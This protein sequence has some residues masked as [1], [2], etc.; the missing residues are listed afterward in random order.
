MP[1]IEV[2]RKLGEGKMATVHLAREPAL[3][4][5]V[6]IKALKPQYHSDRLALARFEREA[7]SAARISHPNVCTV[8]RVGHTSNG[9][10]YIV[11]EYVE[12]RTL[13][14]FI[15]AE[16]PLDPP[17]V[18]K[19]LAQMAAALAAA[20]EKDIVHRD[21]RPDSILVERD[22]ERVMLTDFGL[23][24]IHETGAAP[25]TQLTMVG[26]RLGNP[27]YISPEQFH[28]RPV[29][30]AT[31]IYSLARV[32][33]E[34][35]NGGKNGDTVPADAPLALREVLERCL[36]PDPARR[37]PAAALAAM[38]QRI[39]EDPEGAN[40]LHEAPP[41]TLWYA[42]THFLG[43]LRRRRVYRTAVGY[44]AGV[45]LLLKGLETVGPALKIPD[46][47]YRTTSAV[48]LAGFPLAVTL[49]WLYN[50]STHGIVRAGPEAARR[51]GKLSNVVLPLIGLGLSIALAAL[52]LW[53][54]LSD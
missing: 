20:H 29:S 27:R 53:W 48:L 26:E 39:V 42:A 47:G 1:D 22:T 36:A 31:D 18:A 32:G 49:T 3:E 37:P 10:P 13:D 30:E 40:A 19:M 24:A 9:L 23:A 4:R 7:R 45:V 52:V 28:G 6:A 44:L 12:G 16:S 34:M 46:W 43:E 2:V 14:A 33:I 50:F 11:M 25:D 54:V 15:A 21:L 17:R 35:L 51:R 5:L 41:D 38:L 8:Y